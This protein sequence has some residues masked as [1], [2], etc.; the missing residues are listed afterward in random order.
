MN[1]QQRSFKNLFKRYAYLTKIISKYGH[2]YCEAWR[3]DAN[4][5]KKLLSARMMDW[6]FEWENLNDELSIVHFEEFKNELEITNLHS[7]TGCTFGDL[8]C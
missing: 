1:N 7:P 3:S 6:Q 5:G 4:G 2:V 8:C